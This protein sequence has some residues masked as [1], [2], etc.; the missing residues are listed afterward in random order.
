MN[1]SEFVSCKRP[2]LEKDT[3]NTATS[4]RNTEI[5]RFTLHLAQLVRIHKQ[6]IL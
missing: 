2:Q 4:I 3:K 5:K 1:F 6:I